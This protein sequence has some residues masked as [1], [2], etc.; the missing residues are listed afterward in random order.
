MGR[1][2]A[3]VVIPAWNQWA[4][5]RACLEA[6]RPT[7][8]PRDEVVVVDNGSVD[9]TASALARYGWV[10]VVRNDTNRGFAAACNQG[11][12]VAGGEV[13][14]FLNND[15]LPVGRWLDE[16]CAPF[17]DPT[18]VAT[19]PRSNFVF[20]PQ[21]VTEVA[22]DPSRTGE[23]RR[24]VRD[25]QAAHA[26]EVTETDRLVGFCLAVRREAFWSVGG[27]DEGFGI[28]GFEDDDLCAR[29][30]AAGGRLLIVHAAFVHHHGH[31]TF[32]AHGVDWLAVQESNRRRLLA[33]RREP[34]APQGSEPLISACLIVRDEEAD[35]PACLTAVSRIADEVIVYD[36]G[37]LDQTVAVARGRGAV[38]VEGHW[39]DDFARARNA[40]LAHCRG[41]WVLHVDADEVVTADYD[42]LVR[43]LSDPGAP[44]AFLV[45]VEN[46]EGQSAAAITNRRTHYGCRLFRRSRAQWY[47]RVHEQVLARP[48]QPA[49]RLGRTDVVHIVHA[50]YLADHW[51]ARDK[52]ARNLALAARALAEGDGDPAF[53]ELNMGRALTSVGRHDEA[54]AHLRRAATAAGAGPATRGMAWRCGAELLIGQGRPAEALEWA[55]QLAAVPGHAR[56]AALLAA[57][58]LVELRRPAEA[59]ARL[60]EAGPEVSDPTV[61]Y[62]EAA[63]AALRARALAACGDHAAAAE[64]RLALAVAEPATPGVWADVLGAWA[65]GRLAWEDLAARIPDDRLAFAL[66]DLRRAEAASADALLEALWARGDQQARVLAAATA[67][68]PALPLERAVAWSARL[69]AAGAADRCPLMAIARDAEASPER[70][71]Q[72]AAV[73]A[74]VFDDAEGLAFLEAISEPSPQPA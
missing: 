43:L 44:D 25:W 72:A 47:G 45:P 69:R 2:T 73:A 37:S 14:V 7:L 30:R 55:G 10:K 67:V 3:T 63:V 33:K 68:A 48:G 5:T 12:A 26:G 15:T 46:L 52:A 22:Y 57:A 13:V 29:L 62:P 27:F 20:G 19:G 58:A 17:A 38:V 23:L 56:T 32:D 42:E 35:L 31:A 59:L 40:A 50:G 6:L 9:R 8:G 74:G 51:E 53:L 64:A 1:P 21:L 28:G 66:A 16:L 18:V 65:A 71:V 34:V 49:L 61:A 41:T 11:A 36:T 60:D 24:F 39:D 54:L 4:M 70:R